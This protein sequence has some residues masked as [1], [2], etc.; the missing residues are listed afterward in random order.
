[1]LKG[2]Y[3]AQVEVDFQCE[4]S[5]IEIDAKEL[6]ERMHGG[7][8]EKTMAEV[9]GQMFKGVNGSVKVTQQHADLLEE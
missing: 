3:V 2:R 8:M 5:Q 4:E 6:C 1:M 7:W 9:I